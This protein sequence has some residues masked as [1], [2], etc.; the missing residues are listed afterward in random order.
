MACVS[1]GLV[2]LQD[3]LDL[4]T[5]DALASLRTRFEIEDGLVYLDGNSLGALP[6]AT[7]ARLNEV[8]KGSNAPAD[9]APSLC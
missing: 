1:E 6:A 9:S 4:D 3:V 2:C 7:P 5:N 8:R